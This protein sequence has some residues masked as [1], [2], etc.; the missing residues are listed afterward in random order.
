MQIPFYAGN[1]D[2]VLETLS[3]YGLYDNGIVRTVSMVTS[4]EDE[5]ITIFVE[6]EEFEFKPQTVFVFPFLAIAQLGLS[7][8]LEKFSEVN[9]DTLSKREKELLSSMLDLDNWIKQ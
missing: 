4:H 9:R 7:G 1:K 5:K 8:A 6:F 3:E 2:K